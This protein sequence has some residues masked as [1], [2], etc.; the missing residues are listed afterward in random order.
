[1]LQIIVDRENQVVA[2]CV[3]APPQAGGVGVRLRPV[4]PAHSLLELRAPADLPERA[5]G[6]A[7]RAAIAPILR[8]R[9]LR[10]REP[11]KRTAR[12]ESK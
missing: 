8:E 1:M 7:W 11:G 2:C 9:G 5:D 10:L 3:S 4:N 6:E 12:P